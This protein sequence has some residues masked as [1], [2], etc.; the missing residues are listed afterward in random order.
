MTGTTAVIVVNYSS[1]KLLQ[2]NLASIHLP[3]AAQRVIIIDNF[4]SVSERAAV[5]ALCAEHRWELVT[6]RNDG[7]G[8][9]VNLGVNRAVAA[10]CTSVVLL[11]PDLRMTGATVARLAA[12]AESSP[13]ELHCPMI[14]RPDGS[15]WFSGGDVLLAK[16][17]TTTAPGTS[18]D[19]NTGWLSG[20]CLAFNIELFVR[21]GGMDEDYFMYWEDVDFSWRCQRAGAKLRLHPELSAVHDVGGTQTTTGKSPLY[22][23][24]N[25]RNRLLFAAKH[26]HAPD[27]RRWVSAAVPYAK[28]VILRGGRRALLRRAFPLLWAGLRGSSVG[29]AYVL[30]L[31]PRTSELDRH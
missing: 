7:F 30:R 18:V 6:A 14:L 22:V 17:W 11:N 20:A 25:C 8:S 4:S 12:L 27:R 10:G 16:G 24:Y 19:T 31:T 13:T 2:A 29:I 28:R 15:T 5:A 3:Q 1:H 23:Y 9:G 21:V 26:L